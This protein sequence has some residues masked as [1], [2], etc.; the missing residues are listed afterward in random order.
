MPLYYFHFAVGRKRYP[1]ELGVQFD[2]VEAAYLD[3]FRAAEEMWIELIKKGEDPT[4]GSFEICDT[5]G[6]LLLILPFKEVLKPV[7]KPPLS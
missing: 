7:R 5:N 6:D 4:T 1:D 2:S 3:A